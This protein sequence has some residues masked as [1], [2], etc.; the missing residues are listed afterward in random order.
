M[1]L[2]RRCDWKFPSGLQPPLTK[3]QEFSPFRT[4]VCGIWCVFFVWGFFLVRPVRCWG[5]MQV[6][7]RRHDGCP[8]VCLP[9]L[10]R[11]SAGP[12]R[13]SRANKALLH[14]WARHL[15]FA[16]FTHVKSVGEVVAWKRAGLREVG[17]GHSVA[18]LRPH[19]SSSSS[20]LCD[21]GRSASLAG[22]YLSVDHSSVCSLADMG[23][24]STRFPAL[25]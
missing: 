22:S 16:D 7:C 8:S 4:R 11:P 14:V 13:R 21:G 15:F 18:E 23:L 5:P 20:V 19:P 9:S 10:G 1:T 3:Y 24:V 2:R 12:G 25:W 17:T 6:L